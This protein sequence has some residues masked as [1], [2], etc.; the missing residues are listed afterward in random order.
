VLICP[1]AEE[2]ENTRSPKLVSTSE[3][4]AQENVYSHAGGSWFARG[5][6]NWS[7]EASTLCQNVDEM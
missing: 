7:Q 1:K 3:Y 5:R 6:L 2:L 4:L